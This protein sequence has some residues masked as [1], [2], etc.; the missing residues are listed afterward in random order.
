MSFEE[1]ERLPEEKPHLEYFG[2]RVV[3][4]PM[5]KRPHGKGQAF[6]VIRL[7]AYARAAGGAAW[8]EA[9]VTFEF[10]DGRGT[11]VPDV[12]YWGPSKPQGDDE[13]SLPPTLA[14][15]IRSADQALSVLF[16]KCRMMCAHGVDVCW[17]FDPAARRAFVFEAG[18]DGDEFR[19]ATPTSAFLPGFQFELAE[20][21]VAVS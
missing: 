10:N 4:K 16:A 6:F 7:N 13:R 17:L 18:V 9:A 15:E 19:G 3:Q 1:F 21:W 11:R 12:A 8:A 2:G 14:I 20:L 5:P